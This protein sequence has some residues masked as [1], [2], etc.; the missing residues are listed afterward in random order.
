MSH[1]LSRS[2][3]IAIF[4]VFA[5]ATIF[6]ASCVRAPI[7]VDREPAVLASVKPSRT[8]GGVGRAMDRTREEVRSWPADLWRL[9]TVQVDGV[10]LQLTNSIFNSLGDFELISVPL[11]ENGAF[12]LHTKRE[13][14][15][16]FDLL[17]TWTVIDRFNIETHIPII[18]ANVPVPLG[19]IPGQTEVGFW[20]GGNT[21]MNWVNIRQVPAQRYRELPSIEEETK[22]IQLSAWFKNQETIYDAYRS[23][24]NDGGVP[25]DL[26]S[27]APT[28]SPIAEDPNVTRLDPSSPWYMFDPSIRPRLSKLINRVTFPFRLPVNF[29]KYQEMETGELFSYSGFGGLELGGR[30][31]WHLVDLKV[32]EA[33]NV[34]ANIKTYLRGDFTISVYK[35]SER[36]AKVKVSRSR[37]TGRAFSFT[38]ETNRAVVYDGFVLWEDPELKV[39]RTRL[40]IQPYTFTADRNNTDWFDVG[41][42]Y[43]LE[44]EAAREAFERAVLGAFAQSDTLDGVK[45]SEGKPVVERIFDRSASQLQ[46]KRD[47]GI[48]LSLFSTLFQG[49]RN[50]THEEFKAVINLPDGKNHVFREM[51]SN[52]KSWKNIFGIYERLRHNFTVAL[53]KEAYDRGEP[54]SIFLI[55]EAFIEDSKTTGKEIRRYISEIERVVGKTDILPDLPLY[56]PRRNQPGGSTAEAGRD[57]DEISDADEEVASPGSARRNGDRVRM[58]KATYG[59]SSFYYGLNIN[60]PLLEKFIRTPDAQ[61]IKVLEMAFGVTQG[62]WSRSRRPD[63]LESDEGSTETPPMLVQRF[64]K[65]WKKITIDQTP[66]EQVH[67][68][69]TLF[70]EKKRGYELMLALQLALAGE[71]LEYFLTAQN[72]AF[73]RVQQRGKSSSDF[74]RILFL[75]DQHMG[76]ERM[77]GGF[78]GDTSATI[79]DVS[80][81]VVGEGRVELSFNLAKDAQFLYFR[82]TRST[83][84]KRF[85]VVSE[86]IVANPKQRFKAGPNTIYMDRYSLDF[87]ERELGNPLQEGEFYLI[88]LGF[89][90]DGTRWGPGSSVRFH[91]QLGN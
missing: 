4:A 30:V 46:K 26:P 50:H 70:E 83:R 10:G 35:E 21:G 86:L 60:R 2:K 53:N 23:T 38:A 27:G 73:G 59:R 49:N 68:L 88:N 84:W 17:N 52:S 66:E 69:G 54:D 67:R 40:H 61:K 34:E 11:G 41:Y 13:V 76:F 58:K 43:D 81:R 57:F 14:Y 12:K 32:I 85:R 1:A 91:L 79:T 15:D 64:F 55:A 78:R 77:A 80:A 71:E 82:L 18:N 6:V 89:T 37:T 48:K 7:H 74:D 75:A 45:N 20:I 63:Y 25:V 90:P 51:T 8:P 3:T 62:A 72:A 42:R 29:D 47:S 24:K 87:L 65:N 16:N 28:P 33:L 36:F 22:K 5:A 56:I 9:L 39:G 19:P 44:N 31:G